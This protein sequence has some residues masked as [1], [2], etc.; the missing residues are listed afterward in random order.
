MTLRTFSHGGGVQSTAALVLTAQGIIDYPVHLFAN[1]GDDSEAPETLDYVRN[2]SKPYADKHGIQLLELRYTKR[3]GS[4][5][6]LLETLTRK[7]SRSIPIPVRVAPVGAPARRSCTKHHKIK[8]LEK[9]HRQNGATEDS[10]ATVG[11]G[12]TVDELHRLG[13]GKRAGCETVEYPLVDL[14][15]RR[16]D[17]LN[18]IA[19]E[20]L[21]E[22][23][24]SACWFCPMHPMRTWSEIARD[25]PER[26]AKVVELERTLN[27]NRAERGMNPVYITDRM[28]PM[29]EAIHEAQPSLFDQDGWGETCDEG[30]CFLRALPKSGAWSPWCSPSSPLGSVPSPPAQW[31]ATQP[32]RPQRS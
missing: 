18:L 12:F 9:W 14:M 17:C 29:D 1:V 24:K 7:G 21:P 28:Q 22:P 13:K 5:P 23:P 25:K 26:F 4:T 6:T 32:G 15:L 27:A 31:T 16:S 3:D 2:I 30:V 19:R 10:P 8:V 11:I 20:G